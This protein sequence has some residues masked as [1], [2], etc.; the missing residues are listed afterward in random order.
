MD[1]AKISFTVEQQAKIQMMLDKQASRYKK[2]M[3]EAG[4]ELERLKAENKAL[5]AG[6]KE[7][8]KSRL[9]FWRR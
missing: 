2:N 4:D 3:A 6:T 8:G 1:D 5:R 7:A 9:A